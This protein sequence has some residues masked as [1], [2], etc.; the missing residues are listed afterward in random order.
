MAE[1]GSWYPLIAFD[2]LPIWLTLTHESL[3]DNFIIDFLN[4]VMKLDMGSRGRIYKHII[5]YVTYKWA[6]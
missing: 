6:Q 2:K 4:C 5:F 3:F 1:T